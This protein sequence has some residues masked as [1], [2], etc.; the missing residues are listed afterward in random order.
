MRM[1]FSR[2]KIRDLFT[3]LF[4]GACLRMRKALL[5]L[6]DPLAN[7]ML[8]LRATLGHTWMWW[9]EFPFISVPHCQNRC[10]II[11]PPLLRSFLYN[12]FLRRSG[13]ISRWYS[14]C[15]RALVKLC[16][17][18]LGSSSYGLSRG[19][20]GGRTSFISPQIA[21]PIGVL[22]GQWRDPLKLNEQIE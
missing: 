22:Y 5:P 16:Q 17:P 20:P 8:C 12:L 13:I 21:V 14:Q 19:F 15:Q 4:A 7:T 6:I 18:C 10:R 2:H 11:G 9:G 3:S 1:S